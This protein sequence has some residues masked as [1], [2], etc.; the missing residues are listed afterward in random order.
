MIILSVKCIC[1]LENDAIVAV[2]YAI[3]D[4]KS[5]K[6]Y[7]PA[8]TPPIKIRSTSVNGN[9]ERVCEGLTIPRFNIVEMCWIDVELLV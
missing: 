1:N 5:I 2:V 7:R 3:E 6:G 8:Q 4:E 9:A